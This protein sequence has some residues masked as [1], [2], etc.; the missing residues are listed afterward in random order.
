VVLEMSEIGFTRD[1]RTRD[2]CVEAI[3]FSFLFISNDREESFQ[4]RE[5]L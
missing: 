5:F 2:P 3:M 1:M 4:I